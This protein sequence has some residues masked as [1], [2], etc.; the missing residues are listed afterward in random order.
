MVRV[1][2]LNTSAEKYERRAGSAGQ[3]YESG[4]ESSSDEEWQ[5][6]AEAAEETWE[7]AIQEAAADGRFSSGVRNPNKSWQEA[8]LETGSRRF[9][10]GASRA[11]DVW[12][13]GFDEFAGVLEALNLEPRG[14]RGSSANFERSRRV[15]EALHNARQD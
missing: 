5:S 9:T 7:Q 8:S 6:N 15:G 11:G 4:V 12:R 2:D 3:D 1:K 14:P 10:E 13:S